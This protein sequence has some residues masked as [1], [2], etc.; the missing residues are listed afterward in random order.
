MNCCA[1]MIQKKK[2]QKIAKIARYRK[3]RKSGDKSRCV[4][5]K[6][7]IN[8]FCPY[9]GERCGRW[10][11]ARKD[12]RSKIV[13]R[14]V[15]STFDERY[16]PDRLAARS[17]AVAR[18]LHKASTDETTMRKCT[19]YSSRTRRPA[20]LNFNITKNCNPASKLPGALT[21]APNL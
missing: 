19:C 18:R 13:P 21:W 20:P 3:C 10:K 17:F 11:F 4:K 2:L 5:N 15:C 7:K 14:I 8:V 6:R 9:S 1:N 12:Q 16:H